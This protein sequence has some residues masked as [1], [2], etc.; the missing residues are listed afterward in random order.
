MQKPIQLAKDEILMGIDYGKTNVGIAIGRNGLAT[1]IG[2]VSGKNDEVAIQ[3]IIKYASENKV[4]KIIMG[5]PLTGDGKETKQSLET[6]KFAKLLKIYSKRQ[7]IFQNEYGTSLEA[8]ENAINEGYSMKKRRATDDL[9][10]VLIL[11]RFFQD[12][13]HLQS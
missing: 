6:R 1:P 9:A 13:E 3:G 2:I 4:Q 8:F 12:L 11:R 10:A 7:I 5:L